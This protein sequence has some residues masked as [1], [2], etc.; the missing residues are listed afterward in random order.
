MHSRA[1]WSLSLNSTL[2][3]GLFI[4]FIIVFAYHGCRMFAQE[5]ENPFGAWCQEN[6]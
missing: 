5:L 1:C 2:V 3:G 6:P 4:T